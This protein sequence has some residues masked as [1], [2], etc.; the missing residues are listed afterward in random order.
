MGVHEGQL[1]QQFRLI[2]R[3]D[4]E[5]PFHGVGPHLGPRGTTH[6]TRRLRWA[7]ARYANTSRGASTNRLYRRSRPAEL[8]LRWGRG[9]SC[10]RRGWRCRLRR[11]P[12]LK[13]L[14]APR[15]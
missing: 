8:L 14:R 13:T 4:D 10:V 6:I 7:D 5:A 9:A 12:T 2:P 11:F 15:R 3:D 1:R